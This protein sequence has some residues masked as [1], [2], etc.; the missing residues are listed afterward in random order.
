MNQLK[1]LVAI[2]FAF[3]VAVFAVSN[4]QAVAIN[5]FGWTVIQ[6]VSLVVVVLGAVLFGVLITAVMGFLAQTKLKK[7]I[8]KLSKEN[9]ELKKKEEK[10]QL[11]IRELEENI[12]EE[13]GQETEPEEKTE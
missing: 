10:L 2:L 8:S 7:N 5:F 1:L 11:K 13:A 9:R 12:E 6:N 3:V 4:P